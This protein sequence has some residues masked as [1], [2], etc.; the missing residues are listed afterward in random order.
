MA[1]ITTAEIASAGVV[2]A[3]GAGFPT[4]VKLLAKPDTIVLNAAE[5]EP[6]LHKDKEMLLHRTSEVIDG[7]AVAMELTGAGRAVIGIKHKYHDV[8][9]TVKAALR[10]GMEVVPIP[11]AYP[12]GDEMTLVYETL[13][14]VIPPG[15]LPIAVGVVV[16]NVETARNLGRAA[17]GQGPV[18]EKWLTVGGAVAH[19]VTIRVP[20]GIPF[21]ECL[22]AA[23]GATI[24]EPY[25]VNGGPMMGP[26]VTDFDHAVV[27]KTTGGIL[28]L[29]KTTPVIRNLLR[30]WNGIQRIGKSACDQCCI[31]T[32]LCPRYLLGHPIEPHRAMRALGFT[33]VGEPDVA[34]TQFCCECNLCSHFSCPE[35][36]DPRNVCRHNR[37]KILSERRKWENPPFRPDR[38]KLLKADRRAPTSRL[39]GRLGLRPYNVHAALVDRLISTPRVVIKLKQHVGAPCEPLVNVGERVHIGQEI[40]RPPV[41][42]G[43]PALGA[44]V[45]A[46]IDGRVTAIDHG[47]VTIAAE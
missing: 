37:Q 14:R 2:G 5:C 10:T 24:D 27:D 30:D 45:H 23:G 17:A 11:D 34:G 47:C 7:V 8:I 9:D 32:Q 20:I 46:S 22:A 21:A 33:L 42:D 31:C 41:T 29:P 6:L 19:P 4:Y 18:T 43:K 26:L 44:S 3:G 1:R 39:I 15:G 13:G 38:P 25:F 40:G 28:V 16:M 12:S 36:L 35:G